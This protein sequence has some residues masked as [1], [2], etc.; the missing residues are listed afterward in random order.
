[1]YKL[2][3]T[4]IKIK[5]DY[6]FLNRE[7]KTKGYPI[8]FFMVAK[9]PQK[10]YC[11]LLRLNKFFFKYGNIKIKRFALKSV[12]QETKAFS[13]IFFIGGFMAK[14]LA[15]ISLTYQMPISGSFLAINQATVKIL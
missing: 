5:A 9:A 6:V 15:K 4:L 7:N 13:K 1:M 8:C 12:S 2:D 11:P 3:R 14:Q 10:M